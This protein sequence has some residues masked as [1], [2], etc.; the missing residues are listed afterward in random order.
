MENPP[1]IL[2]GNMFFYKK[3]KHGELGVLDLSQDLKDI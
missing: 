3:V 2:K 1:V